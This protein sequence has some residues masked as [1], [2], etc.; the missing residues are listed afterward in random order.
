VGVREL[1]QA[2]EA[3]VTNALIGIMPL[4]YVEG[5]RI[6]R[7]KTGWITKKLLL[8]Y[9]TIVHSSCPAHDKSV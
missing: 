3:F 4:T 7:G 8:A 1:F 9:H 5:H 6:G 2:E